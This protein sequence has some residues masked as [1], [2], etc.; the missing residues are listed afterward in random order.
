MRYAVL[1]HC[2]C[3]SFW[4]VPVCSGHALRGSRSRSSVWSRPDTAPSGGA[5]R[6]TVY[7]IPEELVFPPPEEAGPDG[8]LGV[9]GDL[10]S[11]RLL[12]AYSQGIFPW[13]DNDLPILWYSPDPR[14][15]LFPEQLRV[16]RSLAKTLRRKHFDIRMDTAFNEVVKGCASV[17]R[18][19][20]SGTW[21]TGDMI[22]AYSRLHALGFAHSA[23]AWNSG[24]L[25]G[26]VYGVSLGRAFFGESMFA[27]ASDASKVAFVYLVRQLQ[28]W[29]FELIDCQMKSGHL[30]RFG[31]VDI[32]R[33]EFLSL[34]AKALRGG[35]RRGKWAFDAGFSPE[36][37]R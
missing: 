7:R 33:T 6:L 37:A 11:E 5:K 3:V 10:S 28:C 26:G 25:L 4:A 29:G 15:V 22:T 30:A 16:G 31:A 2:R 19:G 18:P 32:P 13:Y 21:I 36:K 12:L 1:A 24:R 14:T 9:G 35:T 27:R 17:K 23:E 34:L 20:S 8:L